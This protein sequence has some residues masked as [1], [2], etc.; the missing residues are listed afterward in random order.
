MFLNRWFRFCNEC[1][2]VVYSSC[3][4]RR[5]WR[6]LT[7]RSAV[8]SNAT[9]SRL[10]ASVV[11][12]RH[13]HGDLGDLHS[14]ESVEKYLQQLMEEYR[15]LSEKLQ[16]AHLSESDRKVLLKRHSE[17]L[18]AAAG[19][20]RVQRALKE[21]QEVVSLLHSTSDLTKIR[22]PLVTMP[23]NS[24][25]GYTNVIFIVI[26]RFIRCRGRRQT[27]HAAAEGGGRA[28]FPEASVFKERCRSPLR[29]QGNTENRVSEYFPEVSLSPQLVKALVPADPLDSSNI[30]L[31]VVSGRT[32]GGIGCL[33]Y[34]LLLAHSECFGFFLYIQLCF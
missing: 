19:C 22:D 31:E 30:L 15:N 27:I 1:S 25:R 18:P 12:R 16:H 5:G 32:T 13:F 20:D 4:T 24:S 10:C 17:L 9:V 3:G 8:K 28:H 6:T 11:P 29:T 26:S 14:N 23:G 21:Q 2:R 34:S 33:F 7:G